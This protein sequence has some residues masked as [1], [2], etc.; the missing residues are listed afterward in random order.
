MT[1]V[2][3]G[4]GNSDTSMEDLCTELSVSN[5]AELSGE[6]WLQAI[7]GDKLRGG[8]VSETTTIHPDKCKQTPVFQDVG[9]C[10]GFVINDPRHVL[11]LKSRLSRNSESD[12]QVLA[13]L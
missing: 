1:S 5:L 12:N 11:A 9:E 4:N 8:D 3:T 6:D 2:E 13:A 7:V 10:I